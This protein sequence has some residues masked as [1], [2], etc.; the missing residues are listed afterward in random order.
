M[1]L[2]TA[3]PY[4]FSENS[5]FSKLSESFPT[6]ELRFTLPTPGKQGFKFKNKLTYGRRTHA[7]M[8]GTCLTRE[9][10]VKSVKT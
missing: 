7:V 1:G 2:D 5:E 10:L 9:T 4:I 3:Y 8:R 6:K